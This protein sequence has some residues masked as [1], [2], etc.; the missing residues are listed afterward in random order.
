MNDILPAALAEDGS[1]P[2]T[3]HVLGI[4]ASRRNESLPR[5]SEQTERSVRA[6]PA[7]P[8]LMTGV[9]PQMGIGLEGMVLDVRR[10]RFAGRARPITRP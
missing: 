3:P 9:R 4:E 6:S 10:R 2:N 1:E 8:H 7:A 5:Q